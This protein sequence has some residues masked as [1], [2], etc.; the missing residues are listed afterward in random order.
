MTSQG[1]SIRLRDRELPTLR[2][3]WLFPYVTSDDSEIS[4]DPAFFLN[5]QDKIQ[6]K[7]QDGNSHT[8]KD[9][10]LRPGAM[11]YVRARRTTVRYSR[12]HS[13]FEEVIY[14]EGGSRNC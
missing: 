3:T 4:R 14:N 2:A 13:T 9:S 11:C 10:V 6:D 7:N 1:N 8:H 5:K 12:V